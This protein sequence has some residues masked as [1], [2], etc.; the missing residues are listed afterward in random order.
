MSGVNSGSLWDQYNANAIWSMVAGEKNSC[1]GQEIANGWNTFRDAVDT[2]RKSLEAA[3]IELSKA[4]PPGKNKSAHLFL[5]QAQVLLDSMSQTISKADQIQD[6]LKGIAVAIG[7]ARV[8]VGAARGEYDDVDDD[9]IPEF[10]D[11]AQHEA[12]EKARNAMR[13]AEALIAEA[14]KKV[15]APR[16]FD[17]TWNDMKSGSSETTSFDGPGGGTHSGSGVGSSERWSATPRP[18]P[19]PN[20][21]P[22]P[23]FDRDGSRLPVDGGGPGAEGSR[24]GGGPDLSKL[25]PSP[26]VRTPGDGPMPPPV[27]TDPDPIGPGLTIGLLTGGASAFALDRGFS[28][29]GT[30][31]TSPM[32]A[33]GVRTGLPSGTVIGGAPSA[34]T[35]RGSGSSVSPGVIGG[36]TRQGASS[37]TARGAGMTPGMHSAQAR[38]RR[39]DE[40][41]ASNGDPTNPWE[42]EEG[43][44]PVI[45]PDRRVYRHEPGAGVIGM[46]R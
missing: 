6:G 21:V 22:P 13:A 2:E 36:A 28:P 16:I 18:V 19:I 1:E 30:P 25:Q 37:A 33:L 34:V 8:E 29:L 9:I 42:V 20:D 27:R 46:G 39:E 44:A 32:R 4:W 26:P 3:C 10:V 23:S 38:G 31:G 15:E 24:P 40:E 17:L 14:A 5:S 35:G 11:D 7:Q 45:E 12:N 41:K 43:V